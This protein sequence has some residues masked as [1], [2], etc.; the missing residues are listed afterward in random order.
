MSDKVVNGYVE[1]IA[2]VCRFVGILIVYSNILQ[3]QKEKSQP[4]LTPLKQL[5]L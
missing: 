2:F 1:S 3:S 5:P 4:C